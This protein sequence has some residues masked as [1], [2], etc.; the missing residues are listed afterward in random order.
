MSESVGHSATLMAIPEPSM[1]SRVRRGGARAAQLRPIGNS[2]ALQALRALAAML[3]V[4]FHTNHS[5]FGLSKYWPD[6][7]FGN[8]FEFGHA[9]VEFFFV[10]SGFI[11]FA[12]HH[13]DIGEQARFSNFMW[14]RMRR[15]YPV[16]WLILLIVAPLYFLL[17]SFGTGVE[18]QPGVILDSVFLLHLFGDNAVILTVSWTLFHEVLFYGVFSLMILNRRVGM[19]VLGAWMAGSVV[20]TWFGAA[21]PDGL[22][23][24]FSPMHLLFAMGMGAAW[25][26]ARR[27][28]P[29]PWLVLLAGTALFFGAGAEEVSVAVLPVGVMNLIYGAG[30]SLVV[31]A[32]VEL[33]RSGRIGVP[34]SLVFLGNASYSVYL[35]HFV[36]LS[37]L[38]KLAVALTH[39]VAVP[40]AI[41]Y[42][43]LVA[44]STSVGV[45]YHL[46]AEVPLLSLLNQV[47]MPKRAVA[48]GLARAEY[49][50]TR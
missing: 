23:F 14:K 18:T 24:Y 15:I 44:G 12:A 43:V 21:V 33:E 36:A 20:A 45:L 13:R 4:L 49:D 2:R 1:V 34:Q 40:H 31:L 35:V 9:G 38:A 27:Q 42:L 37:A 11:I 7:P 48:V 17:P 47:R 32:A 28:I 6:R 30:S 46:Y 10:L 39:H 41:I 29:A 3:V 5:V 26:I 50:P 8:V 22:E 25:L 16:Y 19:A